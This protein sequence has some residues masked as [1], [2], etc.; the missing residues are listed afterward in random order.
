[1]AQQFSVAEICRVIEAK[2]KGSPELQDV[3]VRGEITS[4]QKH[5]SSGHIY[6]TLSDMSQ[7]GA[8]A[9]KGAA[10]SPRPTVRCTYFRFAQTPLDFE[11]KAGLEVELFGSMGI[12]A[13]QSTYSLTVRRV[14]KVGAGDILQ[15]LQQIRERLLKEGLIKTAETRRLL[16]VLPKR[17]GIVTGAGTAAYRDMLKQVQ[18]RYPN[19]EIVLAPAQVQGEAAAASIAAALVEIQKPQWQC[20]VVI[21]GRGGGSAEDLMAFN[22]EAVCRT[23]ATCRIPVVSAVGHQIDHPI[24]DDVA[25]YAAATPTDAAR[26]VFPVIDE[27]LFKVEGFA[28]RSAANVEGKLRTLQE[29][30][31]RSS[32]KEFWEKPY[33]LVKDQAHFLDELESKLRFTFRNIVNSY[34]NSLNQLTPLDVLM[35]QKIKLTRAEFESARGRFD[36]YSPLATLSRGY[37]VVYDGEKIL[38]DAT[39]LKKGASI[40]VQL[41]KG[42]I[43]ADVTEIL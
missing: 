1:M 17:V 40:R 20:E 33:V 43:R 38:T 25:D 18:E 28:K 6:I 13:P 31:L 37:S 36:A 26:A 11:L 29:R 9:P 30:F 12:Y 8:T 2:I 35:A 32:E 7:K 4:Y 39:R 21:V 27:I 10:N 41:A 24:S 34:A 16:P 14:Q 22:D 15:K 19:A 23:I 3:W 42:Q 5:S